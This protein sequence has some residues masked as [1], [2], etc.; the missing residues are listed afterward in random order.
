MKRPVDIEQLL[1]WAFVEELP[2]EQLSSAEWAWKNMRDQVRL[3]GV[4]IDRSAP[5]RYGVIEPPHPDALQVA[6][7]LKRLPRIM[8]PDGDGKIVRVDWADSGSLLFSDM[9]HLA[10][11]SI[12]LSTYDLVTTMISHAVMRRRPRWYVGRI[13]LRRRIGANGRVVVFGRNPQ[14][15]R[16]DDGACCPV[17]YDPPL[18]LVADARA[19]YLVW[20]LA[21][22]AMVRELGDS[23][24]LYQPTGPEAPLEPWRDALGKSPD[25]LITPDVI[26]A[27]KAKRKRRWMPA[28]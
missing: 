15:H 4:S 20:C 26:A 2:K 19:E 9:P 10:L 7:V 3:G 23:L 14:T 13:S 1:T 6:A 27:I 16:Y 8:Y 11:P 18:P 24:T 25:S 12:A 21:L 5:Q 28:V 17:D 22:G